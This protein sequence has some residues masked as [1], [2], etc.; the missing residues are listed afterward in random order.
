[1]GRCKVR[2]SDRSDKLSTLQRGRGACDA[3]SR[4]FCYQTSDEL[5]RVPA[6]SVKGDLYLIRRLIISDHLYYTTS[7]ALN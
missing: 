6:I 1:M 2:E 3:S 5:N 4:L 7:I